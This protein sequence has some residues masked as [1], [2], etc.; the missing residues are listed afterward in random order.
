MLI[1]FCEKQTRLLLVTEAVG[2]V[3]AQIPY[4][5]KKWIFPGLSLIPNVDTV[6]D[7]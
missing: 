1:L 2:R 5:K 4:G 6:S 7:I 3:V